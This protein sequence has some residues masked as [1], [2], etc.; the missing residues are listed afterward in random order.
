MYELREDRQFPALGP[1]VVAMFVFAHGCGVCLGFGG[2]TLYDAMKSAPAGKKAAKGKKGKAKKAG[3]GKGK[4]SKK[5]TDAPGQQKGVGEDLRLFDLASPKGFYTLNLAHP[6]QALVFKD[7]MAY[8][9]PG[10][11]PG[12]K[13]TMSFENIS[14]N[15]KTI[16]PMQL[17]TLNAESDLPVCDTVLVFDLDAPAVLSSLVGKKIP[18]CVLDWVVHEATQR[19]TKETWKRELAVLLSRSYILEPEEVLTVR[20]KAIG[21]SLRLLLN[22]TAG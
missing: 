3:K 10:Q 12:A 17:D 16:K 19:S 6:V 18:K 4:K 22:Y 8:A 9:R 21:H 11:G 13:E 14:L 1:V 7:L 15:G 2:P 5:Q 20:A